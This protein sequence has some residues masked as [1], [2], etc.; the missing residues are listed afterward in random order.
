MR[1]FAHLAPAVQDRLFER[2]PA[3]WTAASP[4]AVLAQALGATLYVPGVRT[5]LTGTL[6]RRA[7]EGTRSM[8]VDLEDAVADDQVDD[9]VAGVRHALAE[10]TGDPVP[11]LVFVRVRT[12][13]HIRV[14]TADLCPGQVPLA[15]F[16]VP[17]F[18]AATGARYLAEVAAASER[19]GQRLLVMPVLETP[20][21]LYRESRDEA[22]SAIRDLLA[23]YREYVLAV[24]IGATDLCGL[25]GI[26][27]DR[28]L[29]IYDVGVV[30]ELIAEVVNHLGRADG[31][32]YAISGPV[33]E[34][35]AGHE[36]IFRPQLRSTPFE[37][38]SA[39][40][41]RQRM[42]LR[43]VDGLLRETVLDRANGLTG[44]TVIHPSHVAVVH[45]LSVVPHE[46]FSD[47][48]DILS[49]ADAGVRA[50]GYRNKMNEMRPHRRWAERTAERAAAFG[51]AREGISHVD[52]LR[53]LLNGSLR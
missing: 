24:R 49:T 52:V 3:E 43:D 10:L 51:V 7:A 37:D 12:P 11:A 22:L 48:T 21:V 31:T 27:R 53:A 25:F 36:R 13:E 9:A 14:V 39:G 4:R 34:Y 17:K 38:R 29:T 42:V 47:A 16:V 23:Q 5:D 40:P 41:L 1:H 2:P 18:S 45:A 35:W 32:G 6:R 28:D 30:A 19:L 33:W 26:R 44:K 8:V 20:D 46:E 15:G 50:S